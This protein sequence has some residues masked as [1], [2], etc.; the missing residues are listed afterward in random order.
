MGIN[1]PNAPTIGQLYPQPALPGVPVYRWDGQAWMTGSADTIGAV[2][3]DAAQT[4]TAAQKA[5]A[6]A[7]I[8]SLK[9][10]YIINGAMQINQGGY[11][12]AAVLA[13]A[14][15]GH[16]QWKAGASGG[17]YSFTQLA[18]STTITIAAGK[19]LIQPIEDVR[20]TG[21]GNY[22]LT[23]TGTA[24]ARA[25]VN[26]LTPSGAYAASPLLITGQTDGTV[27][28]VEFNTGTLSNV[29]LYEGTVAPA[30][31]VPDYASE[32][33]S[34][35]R[36]WETNGGVLQ[37][38]AVGNTVFPWVFVVPKRVAP[39]VNYTG[40]SYSNA[41]SL[42]SNYVNARNVGVQY[43]NSAA[44]GFVGFSFTANARL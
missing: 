38:P 21:G 30:F 18:S 15:Y 37:N 6:R 8:D 12:S 17:D 10:N 19:S 16:D 29:G 36:Y 20:I 39:T 2:R 13:A 26:T 27:M 34:C 40:V 9:K 7:N 14:A 44:N 1:F 31:Q 4:L 24:Q 32:L 41:S 11:V 43:V 3:F 42:T 33:A 28:S 25:G 22:V 5:Q 23:W 35:M